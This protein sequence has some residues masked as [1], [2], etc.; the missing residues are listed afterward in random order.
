MA[1]QAD[2]Q[3]PRFAQAYAR[4]AELVDRRGA[5]EHRRRLLAGAEGRVIEVGAGNGRNFAHYPPAVTR[6]VAVEPEDTLRRLAATQAQ[7]APVPVSVVPGHAE[8][9]PAD[10]GTFDVVVMS[11][12]LCSVP[13]QPRALAEAVRVLRP[14]GQL[15]FYEH[16]RPANP[17]F[18]LLADV[19]TPLW[20]R[21]AGDCRP[22]RDTLGAIR[23][24][25]FEVVEAERF[26]FAPQPG[27]PRL[28]HVLGY[29]RKPG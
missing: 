10:D 9:L 15:R 26:G 5:Y 12:V 22:N 18:G 24:A 29:A 1:R 8:E 27:A 20:R 6:V 4:V 23:R 13:S 17:A 28:T 11:L 7:S 3:H 25:G 2:F 21:F 19:V 14:G 16:V